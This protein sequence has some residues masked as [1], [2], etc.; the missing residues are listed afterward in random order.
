[1][2]EEREELD[3]LTPAEAEDMEE[4]GMSGE[5]VHRYEEFEELRSLIGDVLAAIGE[6]KS[7][8]VELSQNRAAVAVE[9]GAVIVDDGETADID[10]EDYDYNDEMDLSI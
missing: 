3:D 10:E 1:M 8:V 6:L 4:T 7:S 9:S 2:D 5:E